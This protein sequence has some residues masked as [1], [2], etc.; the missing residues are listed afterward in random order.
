M[1]W[2][3]LGCL[4]LLEHVII[5]LGID[6]FERPMFSRDASSCGLRPNHVKLCRLNYEQANRRVTG[7]KAIVATIG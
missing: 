4:S 3:T 2:F 7:L 5:C 1:Y 6:S